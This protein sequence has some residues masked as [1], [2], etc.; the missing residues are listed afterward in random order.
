MSNYTLIIRVSVIKD[1]T[2]VVAVDNTALVSSNDLQE[3]TVAFNNASNIV[4]SIKTL[5]NGKVD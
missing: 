2:T 4:D 5:I 1:E 3:I